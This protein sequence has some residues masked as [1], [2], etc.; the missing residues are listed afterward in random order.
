MSTTQTQITLATFQIA[1]K[2]FKARSKKHNELEEIV[3]M[4]AVQLFWEHQKNIAYLNQAMA[5]ARSYKGLRVNAIKEFLTHFTGAVMVKG[6]YTKG[7]KMEKCPSAF[8]ALKSWLEWANE[9][10]AEQTYDHTKK[11]NN[12]KSLLES[13]KKDAFE[14]GDKELGMKIADCL[15]VLGVEEKAKEE[16]SEKQDACVIDG[17]T[18]VKNTKPLVSEAA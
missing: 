14:H 3:V 2:S 6:V 15:K 4:G 8:N 17:D 16:V 5:A 13:R 9:H 10:A 11:F 1:V 7:G 18:D 12:L